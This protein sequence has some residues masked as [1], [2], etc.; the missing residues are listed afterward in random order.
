M[1]EKLISA[2]V[3][4]ATATLVL[5][6]FPTI[7]LLYVLDRSSQRRYTGWWMRTL[8][9]TISR[10]NPM[11]DIEIEGEMP[12]LSTPRPF[13]T[14][15]NH[16]SLA[17][18]PVI[19]RLPWEMKW[20][21]KKS[22]FRIPIAGWMLRMVHDI[23]VDRADKR[24]R[25]RVLEEASK[26]FEANLPVMFFPEGTRSPDGR[27]HRFSNGPFRLAIKEGIPVLPLA[28]DGTRDAL[29]KHSLVFQDMETTMRLKAFP[30]VETEH[31]TL[32]D[33]DD[34]RRRVRRQIAEQIAKWRGVSME[35][36][37]AEGTLVDS[38]SA[39]QKQPPAESDAGT[40]PNATH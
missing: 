2:W 7:C 31:L 24:S 21:A 22:L 28:I 14:V 20:V 17:D 13:V 26:R 29:P 23:P 9:T 10:V 30:L 33:V 6:W 16:L 37:D 38:P 18:I 11:W 27:V 40:G 19:S 5:A 39:Q 15:C 32:Q 12:D 34:L 4:A 35:E 8:A 1:R 25:A 36:I 3:W